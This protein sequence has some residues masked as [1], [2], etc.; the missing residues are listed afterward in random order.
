MK[1]IRAWFERNFGWM[2]Q[3]PAETPVETQRMAL[4]LTLQTL[5]SGTQALLH[6][7]ATA[8]TDMLVDAMEE[9]EGNPVSIPCLVVQ[10][11]QLR[12]NNEFGTALKLAERIARGH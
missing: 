12:R 3:E 5:D 10:I 7:A 4:D 11:E 6:V 1:S 9:C 2:W 8:S